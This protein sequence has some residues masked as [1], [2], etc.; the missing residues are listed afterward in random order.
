MGLWQ[1]IEPVVG[2]FP[3]S[4]VYGRLNCKMSNFIYLTFLLFLVFKFLTQFEN[5]VPVIQLFT[6][7]QLQIHTLKL[8]FILQLS[9]L[10]KSI[11][12]PIKHLIQ[13]NFSLWT[14]IGH[15]FHQPKCTL[16]LSQLGINFNQVLTKGFRIL[17]EQFLNIEQSFSVI[18]HIIGGRPQQI[19]SDSHWDFTFFHKINCI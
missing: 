14:E 15:T 16:L 5:I 7:I 17:L 12:C 3:F 11:L 9:C 8:I 19:V 1:D 4:Q 13:R 18:K 2:L 6:Q 10:F